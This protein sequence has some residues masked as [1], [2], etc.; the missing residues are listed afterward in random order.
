MKK[1]LTI[2]LITISGFAYAQPK[3]TTYNVITDTLTSRQTDKII[4]FSDT[5]QWS[6]GT[7]QW[8]G[9]DFG[10]T[11]AVG[12]IPFGGTNSRT[13]GVFRNNTLLSFDSTNKRL[14]VGL[15][16][17]SATATG[18]FRGSSAVSGTALLI[19][20]STPQ[21]LL[22][23]SNL[24]EVTLGTTSRTATLS[25]L[26]ASGVNTD[27]ISGY[28]ASSNYVF[29]VNC[30]G[31]GWWGRPNAGI[32][33]GA[34]YGLKIAPMATGNGNASGLV[35]GV[36]IVPAITA[37]ANNQVL[38]TFLV[39]DSGNVVGGFT[40]TVSDLADFMNSSNVSL[41]KISTTNSLA[42][43]SIPLK[44]TQQYEG[45]TT[46]TGA[47]VTMVS[48]S[49][50]IC[51]SGSGT[52]TVNFPTGVLGLPVTIINQT[53]GSLTVTSYL[54]FTGASQTTQAAQTSQTY[55]YDGSNW[56]LKHK[57]N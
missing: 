56:N 15:V 3:I 23:V 33:N 7:K 21:R 53:A 10:A 12:A 6:D 13:G 30:G 17:T 19:E 37:G 4:K 18:H 24:G 50:H 11:L 42:T 40:G 46:T 54:D 57:E 16:Y 28:N 9:R 26:G 49:T 47:T 25:V 2:L 27:L 55:I 32:I 20:N 1:L 35:R 5:I 51:T 29:Y 14:A 34:N 52:T 48:E 31:G 44:T 41:F 8:Q 43:F 45:L 38:T 36:A 39:K 22:E